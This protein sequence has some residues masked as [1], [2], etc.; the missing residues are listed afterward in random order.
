M[1]AKV[2]ILVKDPLSAAS[3]SVAQTED[4]WVRDER[5]LLDG[6][7]SERV[8]ILD[9]DPDTG[10]L[11]DG[12][13][14]VA[15]KGRRKA[16]WPVDHDDLLH[17]D[18]LAVSAFGTVHKALARFESPDALGRKV[19]WAFD[20][21]Q[22]LVVPRAGR[23]A[24]AYYERASR[25]LQFFWFDDVNDPTRRVYTSASQ[26]IVAH[27]ATHAI[28]DGI[29]P[30]LYDATTPECLAIHEAVADVATVLLAI[31]VRDLRDTLIKAT[32]GAMDTADVFSQVALQFATGLGR[33]G[34]LRELDNRLGMAD[35]DRTEPH[36]L[37]V[38]LS[39]A[40][41]QVLMAMYGELWAQALATHRGSKLQNAHKA[42]VVGADRIK[43]LLVRGL[44]YLPPGDS[45]YADLGRAMLA[46]DEASHP[47]T[48][49]IRACLVRELVDRGVVPDDAA[50]EVTTDVDGPWGD[51]LDP[52]ELVA[53]DFVA[54][55]LVAAHR[56]WFGIPDR[57]TFTVL[58]RLDVTKTYVYERASKQVREILL[59]VRWR[60]VEPAGLGTAYP[61]DRIYRAGCTV[62]IDPDTCRVRAVLRNNLPAEQ[63]GH[64]Q[65][66]TALLRRLDHDGLLAPPA[67]HGATR[68][69]GVT[70]RIDD[71]ALVVS[72]TAALLHVHA[73]HAGAGGG[74][75]W[76]I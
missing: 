53:S 72:G 51:D 22:L 50:L 30:D 65:A 20:G 58:P 43:R 40:L 23:D 6:P 56:A 34:P 69:E 36:A 9:V 46:A 54:Y 16:G 75:T 15:A 1:D 66:R 73:P 29:A 18:R 67:G 19:D 24:N 71:G 7:V 27:E 57:R 59:K 63:A 28:L 2:T 8:A 68:A 12:V 11:R 32:G 10:R 48:P 37:S 39:G 60:E 45:G 42:L 70:T 5:V 47:D 26:D 44:D 25:S 33:T 4:V 38:V 74:Q 64:A 17:P 35:V 76:P 62:A 41:F 31:D 21:K 55:E 61:R 13:P 52:D 3:L 14:F 49:F